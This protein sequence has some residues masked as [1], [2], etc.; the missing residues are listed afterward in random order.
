MSNQAR[1][2][3]AKLSAKPAIENRSVAG[4]GIWAVQLPEG[5]K[6]FKF[7]KKGSVR[8]DVI[9]FK[10]SNPRFHPHSPDGTW[11]ERTYFIHRFI[12]VDS[13][14]V[15][16]PKATLGKPCPICDYRTTLDRND[17]EDLKQINALYPKER[18]L[19]N[20]IVYED[21]GQSDI[22]VL[23]QPRS[24][25]GKIVDGM[26]QEADKEDD[27]YQYYADLEA[28][29]TL[30][31]NVD[32]L[33]AGTFKYF[34]ATSVEFKERKET[35]D[36]SII[37]KAVDLD[38]VVKVISYDELKD[39]FHGTGDFDPANQQAT[40]TEEEKPKKTS[41]AAKQTKPADDDE[42]DDSPPAKSMDKR[43]I[44]DNFDEDDEDEPPA[45]PKKK[46]KPP[47]DDDED[48]DE[49]P[50]KPAAKSKAKPPADDDDEDDDADEPPAK[51]K[52]TAKPAESKKR[53]PVEDW[54]DDEDD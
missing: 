23:D 30:K 29:S 37:D 50:A 32:E 20:V 39:M 45:K 54:D 33:N 8:L 24:G 35:Y 17:P 4:R 22:M 52:A 10:I 28:G 42:D 40:T 25:L 2:K 41:K 38:T 49:P 48:E 16:C 14:T 43:G 36:E 13:T 21:G 7:S 1:Q 47:V 44:V 31:V 46:A 5:V 11:Y 34:G 12:G 18:Q 51:P 27:H 19:F 15:V 53:V 26:I 3:R 9:P 6:F